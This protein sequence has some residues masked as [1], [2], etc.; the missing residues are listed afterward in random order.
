MCLA[1]SHAECDSQFL[2][3]YKSLY[4]A[5]TS[6]KWP[7][8][9]AAHTLGLFYLNWYES[10]LAEGKSG[11]WYFKMCCESISCVAHTVPLWNTLFFP[12]SYGNSEMPID[13][14]KATQCVNST[15]GIRA[16]ELV[17]C[18]PMANPQFHVSPF[19]WKA[20]RHKPGLLWLCTG[21]GVSPPFLALRGHKPCSTARSAVLA[22]NSSERE[23]GV[24]SHSPS[25][26]LSCT[27]A[28]FSP[29]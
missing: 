14:P 2:F 29:A 5:L 21:R 17:L 25:Q 23:D 7:W 19:A 12:P 1:G 18:S 3:P 15:T 10:G 22:L 11:A 16:H 13:L 20:C 6:L 27:D 4:T 24:S 8:M 28:Y 26:S 9:S